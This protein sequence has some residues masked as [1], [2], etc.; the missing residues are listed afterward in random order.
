MVDSCLVA[1]LGRYAALSEHDKQ[2]LVALERDEREYKKD[3]VVTQS[4]HRINELYVLKSGWLT[5]YSLL[6][7]GR[8]QLLR[9]FYPGDIVDLAE[10]ALVRARHDVKCLTP[11]VLCPFPKSGLEP[12]FAQSPRLTALLFSMTVRENSTLLDRIRAVGRFSAYERVCYL[13]LEI[14]YR[15]NAIDDA[16]EDGGFRLPLTQSD[17][18][19]LLGLTNVYVSKTMSRIEQDGLIRRDGN[20]VRILDHARMVELCDFNGE[21]LIDTSWFPVL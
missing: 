18:A 4:G 13:L 7:D 21:P 5:S 20:R 2:L 17:I 12:L 19:D 10:I 9:L 14:G 16:K 3:E 1:K 6:D 11:A 8:R 15:L